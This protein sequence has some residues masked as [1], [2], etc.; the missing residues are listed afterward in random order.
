MKILITGANSGMGWETALALGE[1]GH[2]LLLTVRSPSKARELEA[3]FPLKERLLAVYSMDLGDL[4][5]VAGA[6]RQIYQEHPAI[7]V[8]ILNA[9]IMAPPYSRTPDGYES[10]FQAN[11]LGHW[12]LC[13]LLL[14]S[15]RGP[16]SKVI[17]ISSLSSEKGRAGTID[18]IQ[19]LARVEG[20]GYDPMTSYRESKLAQVL[21]TVELQ[22]RYGSQGLVASAVHPG[23]VN[24]NLFYRQ[25]SDLYKT[26]MQPLA[27]LGYLTGILSTPKRGARTAVYLATTPGLP[28][29]RYWASQKE[30]AMNP[31]AQD[32][33]LTKELWDWTNQELGPY[34]GS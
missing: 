3:R 6:G 11:Y 30:R 18:E 8:L 15:L 31:L 21:F 19:A 4:G 7:D 17:S 22:R 12:L 25:G 1:L 5:S 13:S 10:Q 27:W 28:G 20:S 26:L 24:T 32:G 29:G 16:G 2:D 14:P 34:L 9:G 33:G 23:V